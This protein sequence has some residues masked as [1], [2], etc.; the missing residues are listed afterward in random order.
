MEALGR[1]LVAHKNNRKKIREI[2]KMMLSDR[3]MYK[4]RCGRDIL[5]FLMIWLCPEK[6]NADRVTV[7]EKAIHGIIPDIR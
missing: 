1:L 2:R 4:G 6:V 5:I 3:T 7:L